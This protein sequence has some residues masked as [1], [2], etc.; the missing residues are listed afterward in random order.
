MPIISSLLAQ[1]KQKKFFNLVHYF[2]FFLR[3]DKVVS[4][5][6]VL[7]NEELSMMKKVL[8]LIPHP[9]DEVFGMGWALVLLKQMW[10]ELDL[11][12]FSN[13]DDAVRVKEAQEV[14]N[15]LGIWFDKGSSFPCTW[16]LINGDNSEKLIASVL[17]KRE[18]DVICIPSVFDTHHDHVTL[19]HSLKN[20]LQKTLQPRISVLQYEVW[21]TLVPNKILDVT[22]QIEKKKE[23]MWVYISQLDSDRDYIGRI[24][25]LNKYRGMTHK[26][27]Y[28]EAFIL[29]DKETFLKF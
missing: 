4:Y 9:D 17:S 19:F 2:S 10:A 14:C 13:A 25:W 24:L 5:P 1:L 28:G 11:V 21:N 16:D 29:S 27:G 15:R 12:W 18:Y 20:T 6:Q 22:S 3:Q 8:V 26:F 7:A 23:L